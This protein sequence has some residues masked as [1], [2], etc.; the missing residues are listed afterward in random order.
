[1][2]FYLADEHAKERAE[3]IKLA[4]ASD[5]DSLNLL[6]GY[7]RE[8]QREFSSSTKKNMSTHLSPPQV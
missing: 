8:A 4:G 6:R 1:M 2:D 3:V 7:I 5:N